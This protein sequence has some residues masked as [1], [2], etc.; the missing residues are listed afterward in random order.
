MGSHYLGVAYQKS[1]NGLIATN[2][3]LL[4]SASLLREVRVKTAGCS[5]CGMTPFFGQL[6]A[7]VCGQGMAPALC[8]VAVNLQNRESNF[9]EGKT[10][11][12]AGTDLKECYNFEMGSIANATDF[13]I[14]IYHAL[15]DGGQFDWVQVY[16]T[17]SKVLQCEFERF[18]DGADFEHGHNC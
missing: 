13:D 10:D 6:S 5:D 16:L 18:L 4:S 12:F 11:I 1:Q 14:T 3:I 15:T 7:K 17:D 8:C 2:L 9:Q